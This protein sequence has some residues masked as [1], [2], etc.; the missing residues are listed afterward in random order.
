V[1]GVEAD[2]LGD[3]V[4]SLHEIELRAPRVAY[5]G[6][7]RVIDDPAGRAREIRLHHEERLELVL[8][9]LEGG[10]RTSYDVSLALFPDDLAPEI[11]RFAVVESLAH[12]EHLHAQG[13]IGRPDGDPV[14]FA[15]SDAA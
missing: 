2:P 1:A 8:A 9:A 15:T 13:V 6:H 5:P 3:F 4:A 14:R 10:P 11:R 12:L 7:G